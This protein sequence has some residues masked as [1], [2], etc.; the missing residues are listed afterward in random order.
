MSQIYQV[1]FRSA[2][3]RDCPVTA[4]VMVM[5]VVATAFC[6]WNGD[7]GY[8]YFLMTPDGW[9]TQPWRLIAG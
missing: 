2:E 6:W 5:C 7:E 3:P 8:S 4:A 1:Q 9:G